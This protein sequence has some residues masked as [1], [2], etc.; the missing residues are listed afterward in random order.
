MRQASRLRSTWNTIGRCMSSTT[1]S[2]PRRLLLAG[3][4]P[5]F[6]RNKCQVASPISRYSTGSNLNTYSA[7]I[8]NFYSQE[9]APHPAILVSV[10][11]GVEEGQEAGVTAFIRFDFLLS[12]LDASNFLIYHQVPLLAFTP[13]QKIVY[14][15]LSLSIFDSTM[16][17]GAD[18]SSRMLLFRAG[19]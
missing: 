5:F 12:F 17:K 15:F 3:T 11:S 1:R 14:S 19:P 4:L 8:Q 16:L 7:L 6:S 13:S 10:N 2:T 18:V 9:T